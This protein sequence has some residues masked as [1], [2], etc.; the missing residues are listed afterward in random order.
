MP[1]K[2]TSNT[3]IIIEE[4]SNTEVLDTSTVTP[5]SDNGPYNI[6]TGDTLHAIIN[7]GQTE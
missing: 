4:I 2:Q 6:Y 3:E 5:G 1:K 7:K